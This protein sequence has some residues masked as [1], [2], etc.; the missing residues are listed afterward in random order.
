MRDAPTLA[1]LLRSCRAAVELTQEQLAEKAGISD[2]A[3]RDL[4]SGRTLKPH[5]KTLRALAKVLKVPEYE[6]SAAAN[7]Q[8]PGEVRSQSRPVSGALD[9]VAVLLGNL[10]QEQWRAEAEIRGLSDPRP[11]TVRWAPAPPELSD[12]EAEAGQAGEVVR[13]FRR[14]PNRRL[15]VL[16]PPGAGKTG[17]LLLLLLGLLDDRRPGDPVPVLLSPSSWNP[18]REKFPT[19]L[20]RRLLEDYPRLRELGAGRADDLVAGER[21]LPLLDGLDELPEAVRERAVERIRVAGPTLPLVVACRTDEYRRVAAA[22]G[23]L[24]GAAAIELQPVEPAAAIDYLRTSGDQRWEKVLGELRW[25][26]KGPL[27][28]ALS[29]PLMVSLASTVYGRAAADPDRLLNAASRRAVEEHLLDGLIPAA[30]EAHRSRQEEMDGRWS[31]EQAQ[32]WLAFLASTLRERRTRDLAWWELWQSKRFG[33]LVGFV[34]AAL[35]AVIAWQLPGGSSNGGLVIEFACM[36]GIFAAV[37]GKRPAHTVLRLDRLFFERFR[38]VAKEWLRIGANIGVIALVL[39]GGLE[40]LYT[41]LGSG[42]WAGLS[43]ALRYG[44]VAGIGL[45]LSCAMAG[46]ALGLMQGLVRESGGPPSPASSVRSDRSSLLAIAVM[47]A[48][49]VVAF[50]LPAGLVFWLATALPVGVH[51]WPAFLAL[52]VAIPYVPLG[53]GGLL[54]IVSPWLVFQATRLALALT[55]RLPLRVMAFLDD[56]HCAG[57]L[58]QVGAVYQFRHAELQDWLAGGAVVEGDPWW[59]PLRCPGCRKTVAPWHPACPRCNTRLSDARRTPRPER[60]ADAVQWLLVCAWWGFWWYVGHPAIERVFAG[61]LALALLV[62]VFL[63]VYFAVGVGIVLVEPRGRSF[64]PL[65]IVA[66]ALGLVASTLVAIAM[67]R[68]R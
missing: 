37:P 6:L 62:I 15:V 28:Q 64:G 14:L 16:G 60:L 45:G 52:R 39:F 20:R 58:R 59:R 51:L 63:V 40:G 27:A 11:L 12:A 33:P 48:P 42:A 35:F 47:A 18:G 57:V 25:R 17:L 68:R 43:A 34:V 29:T 26:P 30:F 8:Q 1:E 32:R 9:D 5:A 4:E 41:G 3:I 49:M 22:T 38:R 44:L 7:R 19:W 65:W 55:G 50:A 21:V 66:F 36:F 10:V 67:A 23:P 2:A 56:A 46:V 13:A 24:R 61:W 31:A 54:L 53:L